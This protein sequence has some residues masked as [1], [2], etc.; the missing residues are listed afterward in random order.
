MS[1]VRYDIINSKFI[2]ISS[3]I[4]MQQ[5]LYCFIHFKITKFLFL[6]FDYCFRVID[7]PNLAEDI[8]RRDCYHLNLND[9]LTNTFLL[10][11]YFTMVN[12]LI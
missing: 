12:S 8:S 6:V 5:Y 1:G 4:D 7:T 11:I 9:F 2:F 3:N 10:F